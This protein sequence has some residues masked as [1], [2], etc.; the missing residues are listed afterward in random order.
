MARGH[1]NGNKWFWIHQND[2]IRT[3]TA[4]AYTKN[5]AAYTNQQTDSQTDK[6]S[7]YAV[8][9]KTKIV[10]FRDES[11]YKDLISFDA[12]RGAFFSTGKI[13]KT[14]DCLFAA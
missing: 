5:T 9:A 2:V 4:V 3:K 8:Y 12:S 6:W 10:F 1:D 11:I 14:C 7:V 13:F